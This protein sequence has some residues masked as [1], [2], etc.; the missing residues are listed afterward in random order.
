M[1]YVSNNDDFNALPPPRERH[2]LYWSLIGGL[3]SGGEKLPAEEPVHPRI[4]AIRAYD[5]RLRELNAPPAPPSPLA[6]IAGDIVD[7][8]KGAVVKV[9]RVTKTQAAVEWLAQVLQHGPVAQTEIVALATKEGI[10]TKPLKLAKQKLKVAST[11]KGANHWRWMLPMA[12]AK[13][14]QD[15]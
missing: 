9:A 8:A 11:R 7:M 12:K 4:A 15:T 3:L 6:T 13:E 1:F 14:G 10:G 2:G 5:T